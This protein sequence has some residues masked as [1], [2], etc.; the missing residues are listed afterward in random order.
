MSAEPEIAI[1]Q[2]GFTFDDLPRHWF[3]GDPVP[4][5]VV[6][7]LLAFWGT[8]VKHMLDQEP[9]RGSK[10]QRRAYGLIRESITGVVPRLLDYLRPSFHPDDHDNYQLAFDY[11]ESTDRLAA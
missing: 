8:G 11:L 2:M 7:G 6:N 5:H 10:D 9:A 1:R 3:G 4:T